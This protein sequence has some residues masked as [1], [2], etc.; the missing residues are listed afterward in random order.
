LSYKKR[1]GKKH[2]GR[3]KVRGSAYFRRGKPVIRKSHTRRLPFFGP[4][5]RV[6]RDKLYFDT[7]IWC[8][9]K[10]KT[11]EN[12]EAFRRKGFRAIVVPRKHKGVDGYS[13][14]VGGRRR[15]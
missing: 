14:Y 4:G 8:A 3:V 5:V 2:Y 12:A 1:P 11:E 15:C 13:V 10:E 9:I 7:G 6:I